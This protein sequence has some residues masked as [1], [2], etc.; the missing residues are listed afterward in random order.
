MSARTATL[1]NVS[2]AAVVAAIAGAVLMP[3]SA[4]AAEDPKPVLKTTMSAPVPSGPLTRG[5]A[6]ETFELTVTNPT[7][8]TASYHPWMLLDHTGGSP[9]GRKDVV[10]KVE[11]V[12][13]PATE[14][15]VIMQ[16]GG[17]QGA[18]YP[19]GGD[20]G[21]AFE[22]PAGGKMVW[23][24]TIGLDKNY[25]T[26]DGDFTLRA[27]SLDDEIAKDGHSSLAFKTSPQTKPGQLK[28]WYDGVTACEGTDGSSCKELNLHYK[29]T[30]EGEFS[31]A[32]ATYFDVNYLNG[33]LAGAEVQTRI[34]V[35]G[36]W[37]D[38]TDGN[39]NR[40]LP[41]IPKGFGAASGERVVRM[42]VKL[43]PKA[44]TN[45]DVSVVLST[46]VGL[47]EGNTYLFAGAEQKLQFTPKATTP[48]SPAP[49]TPKPASSAPSSPAPSCSLL[50]LT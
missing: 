24:F 10:F 29:V 45:K 26:V 16:D 48:T 8:K 30:G 36:T 37:K 5:G 28:N 14:S 19:A 50:P 13:A 41:V 25:P 31:S 17:W 18:F 27:E 2:A 6:T 22:I 38:L 1:R 20:S 12:S 47:A 11:P 44:P 7:D 49:A 9:V 43:G 42:Q 23:K 3:L 4:H 34:K 15:Y 32:L 35:D 46:Q 33:D 21:R 39:G 40:Q